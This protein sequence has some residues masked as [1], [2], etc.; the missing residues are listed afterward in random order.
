M[1][2]WLLN[3]IMFI[4][5][6]V[7]CQPHRRIT[8]KVTPTYARA[9]KDEDT[10]AHFFILYGIQVKFPLTQYTPI[11]LFAS[12]RP[13]YGTCSQTDSVVGYEQAIKARDHL[14]VT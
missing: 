14:H 10:C 4:S 9:G 6:C 5:V 1:N 2:I 11:T 8:L 7:Y 13:T 12:Y 3:I